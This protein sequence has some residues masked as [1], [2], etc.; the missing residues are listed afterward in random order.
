[1]TARRNAL[2]ATSLV[3]LVAAMVGL[4]Y[5]SVPLYRLFCQVTGFGGTTQRALAAPSSVPAAL[6]DRVFTVRFDATVNS[7][8]PWRFEP[9]QGEMKVKIGEQN[10]ALYRVVNLSKEDVTGSATFN[11]NP[12]IAGAYFSKIACFCFEEQTLAAGQSVEMPVSFFIDPAV[13]KD[14]EMGGVKEIVLS[15]TFFRA[16]TQTRKQAAGASRAT[17]N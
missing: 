10:L 6:A 2:L 5:A 1:M 11:V 17:A 4:S 7:N 14:W 12:P 3:G 15:Y 9:V 8:L 13:A 16:E